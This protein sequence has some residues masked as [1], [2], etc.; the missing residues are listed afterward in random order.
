MIDRADAVI[1][2]QSR[3]N[4]LE[5]LA[6]GQHVRNAAGNAEIVFQNRKAPVRQPHQ[7][8]S[9]NIDV[10]TARNAEVTHLATIVPAAIDEFLG[11]NPVREYSPLVVD[12]SQK[13]VKR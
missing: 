4:S 7:I 11:H 9:A 5:N 3:K 8:R 6:I 12:V 1:A 2:K 10:N 13:Q